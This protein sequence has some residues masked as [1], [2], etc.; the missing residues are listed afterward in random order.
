MNGDDL[1]RRY[2]RAL[3]SK[4]LSAESSPLSHDLSDMALT[5]E[6]AQHL[7]KVLEEDGP[8]ASK[9]EVLRTLAALWDRSSYL[10]LVCTDVAKQLEEIARGEGEGVSLIEA[11]VAG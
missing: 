5:M 9:E 2:R 3:M 1:A 4:E 6:T 10:Q 8:S 7:L 11:A